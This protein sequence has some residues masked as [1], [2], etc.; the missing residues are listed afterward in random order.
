MK[1]AI[2]LS[3]ACSIMI[4]FYWGV[5]SYWP[6]R[7]TLEHLQTANQ[8]LKLQIKVA[9][10]ANKNLPL[11][12]TEDLYTWFTL[13][14][15]HG[16][17]LSVL[18]KNEIS[19]EGAA[20]LQIALLNALSESRVSSVILTK[21]GEGRLKTEIAFDKIVIGVLSPR[22]QLKETIIVPVYRKVLGWVRK[23]GARFCVVQVGS[24]IIL[25]EEGVC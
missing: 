12:S 24:K 5:C 21:Q 6:N 17:S 15:Q 7:I 3:L 13:Q 11:L 10:Q 25:Q 23:Q 19:F 22:A 20:P 1:K 16:V 2:C 8:A 14:D 4:G 18:S 9:K